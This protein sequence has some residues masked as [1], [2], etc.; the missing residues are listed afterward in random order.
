MPIEYT[1][2]PEVQ[3]MAREIIREY[4]DHL[5]T[6]SVKIVFLFTDEPVK[7]RGAETLGTARK[8]SGLTAFLAQMDIENGEMLA[9]TPGEIKD[10]FFVITIWE[11][12]WRHNLTDAQK[13][14]LLDHELCHCY[15]EEEQSRQ[16]GEP[17]GVIKLA[18]LPHNLEEFH[19]IAA[20]HGIWRPDINRFLN[21]LKGR[22]ELTLF[23][24]NDASEEKAA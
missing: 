21:A 15:S 2:A 4:H 22:P 13:R 9:D 20:R 5:I 7:V 18:V 14:A 11:E 1:P 19:V 12:A 8:V 17:T 23:S 24:L 3:K 16:T 6:N 10:A